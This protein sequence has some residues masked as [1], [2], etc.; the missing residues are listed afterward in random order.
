[1]PEMRPLQTGPCPPGGGRTQPMRADHLIQEKIDLSL[2]RRQVGL[3]AGL[4]LVLLGGV[5]A[6]G[7]L[8]GRQLASAALSGPHAAAAGDLAALDAQK[9]DAQLPVRQAAPVA[10]P[11]PAGPPPRAQSAADSPAPAPAH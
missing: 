7:V 3:L 8:V 6:L 2:E 10:A 1:M 4:A 11:A 9:D 5:F